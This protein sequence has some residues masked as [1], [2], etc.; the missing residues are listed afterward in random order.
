MYTYNDKKQTEEQQ[1]F[2]SFSNTTTQ[3]SRQILPTKFSIH[4]KNN[5]INEI[6]AVAENFY[7]EYEIGAGTFGT[8]YAAS[9]NRM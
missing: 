8:V 3:T 1:V 2:L 9:L 7:I 6:P 5:L 4:H